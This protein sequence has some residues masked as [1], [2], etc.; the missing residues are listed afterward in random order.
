MHFPARVLKLWLFA[1]LCPFAHAQND[2]GNFAVATPAGWTV[3]EGENGDR[4]FPSASG[5]RDQAI[6]TVS[7]ELDFQA[8]LKQFVDDAAALGSENAT[9]TSQEPAQSQ[10]RP[11]GGTL[12]LK[13]LVARSAE[14]TSVS[15]VLALVQG[16]DSGVLLMTTPDEAAAQK[17]S[18]DFT[19]MLASVRFIP[20][21]VAAQPSA[22]G[23]GGP[24][25]LGVKA[26][27]PEVKPM[28]ATQFVAAGATPGSLLSPMNFAATRCAL[29]RA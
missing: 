25:G 27:L 20:R 18:R 13:S 29:A 21:P 28:N 15:Y 19:G 22:G 5:G 14:G 4:Y 1:L 2:P 17:Y 7:P 9:V 11:S 3:Q 8:N 23:K 6:V 26:T 24:L 16:T 10:N 12:T